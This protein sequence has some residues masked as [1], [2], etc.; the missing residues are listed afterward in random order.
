[1]K[2]YIYKSD[3]PGMMAGYRVKRPDEHDFHSLEDGVPSFEIEEFREACEKWQQ[4]RI[5]YLKE[6]EWVNGERWYCIDDGTIGRVD[7]DWLMINESILHHYSHYYEGQEVDDKYFCFVEKGE[8]N[9]EY[10]PECDQPFDE[11][12]I[13]TGYQEC[14]CGYESP[15]WQ[16]VE[17]PYE[18]IENPM[19]V[20]YPLVI[21]N[22][23]YTQFQEE[24]KSD[25]VLVVLN[26]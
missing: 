8:T 17:E 15:E 1:M 25:D 5:A 26:T 24:L 11:R 23:K 7:S 12:Y 14:S 21:T 22:P 6:P 16:E 19:N 9:F 18:F 13:N 20:K 3:K 4:S 10:C 2:A